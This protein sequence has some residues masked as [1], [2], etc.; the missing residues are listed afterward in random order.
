METALRVTIE[1]R[2]LQ[3]RLRTIILQL[4]DRGEGLMRAIGYYMRRRTVTH[5]RE[6]SDPQGKPWAEL[7][8]STVAAR[9][10]GK[11]AKR[12]KAPRKVSILQD[13]GTLRGR[14]ESIADST[15]VDIG[16]NVF[17]GPFH[18][19]GAPRANIPVREFLGIGP[20]D[21]RAIH[22]LAWSYLIRCTSGR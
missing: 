9:R 18:Q 12:G 13:T 19:M 8:D 17:Y 3:A 21:A 1:D 6:E 16:T 10:I 2:E 14:I 5:F 20:A 15:S 7:A 22:D 4:G 11:K